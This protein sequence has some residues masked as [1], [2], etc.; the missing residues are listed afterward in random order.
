VNVVRVSSGEQIHELRSTGPVAIVQLAYSP[1]GKFIIGQAGLRERDSS[2]KLSTL[3]DGQQAALYR[4][5]TDRVCI[6]DAADGELVVWLPGPAFADGFGPRGEL[7]VARAIRLGDDAWLAIDLWR[8]AELSGALREAGIDTRIHFPTQDSPSVSQRDWWIS[9]LFFSALLLHLFWLGS[10]LGRI[11]QKRITLRTA[12]TGIVLALLLIGGGVYL[13]MTAVAQMQGR[14]E[15]LFWPLIPPWTE[16]Q[17]APQFALL[18]LMYFLVA[19]LTG[20]LGIKCYTHLAYGETVAFFDQLQAPVPEAEKKRREQQARRIVSTALRWLLG[21]SGITLAVLYLDGSPLLSL[22]A[23]SW[24]RGFFAG[25]SLLFS[26]LVLALLGGS[27]VSLVLFPVLSLIVALFDAKWGPAR[28]PWFV[29]PPEIPPTRWSR[30]M[31][32]VTNLFPL[33][34]TASLAFWLIVLLIGLGLTAFELYPRLASGDWPRPRQNT[35]FGDPVFLVLGVFYVLESILRL[36]RL[37]RSGSQ[38]VGHGSGT[39]ISVT[40]PLE[41]DGVR[42]PSSE[43]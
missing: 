11:Q 38:D 36:F 37:M 20:S 17:I 12:H 4:K 5:H 3:S 6:W 27:L 43:Q 33:S 7:A 29:H 1:D 22:V 9:Q 42:E 34:R 18:G 41:Q 40:A 19:L 24:K 26:L 23:Y 31:V 15:N 8:P 25:L 28:P 39:P 2:Y 16:F 14:W 30:F 32:R 21:Y 35:L 10:T 13:W